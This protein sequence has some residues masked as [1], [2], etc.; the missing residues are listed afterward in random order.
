[1][2][3]HQMTVG[4]TVVIGVDEPVELGTFTTRVLRV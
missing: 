2:G 1:L 3:L 4:T